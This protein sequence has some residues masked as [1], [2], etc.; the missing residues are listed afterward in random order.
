MNT[1]STKQIPWAEFRR[2]NL[3]SQIA[4]TVGGRKL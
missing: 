1:I 4:E 3:D 2:F